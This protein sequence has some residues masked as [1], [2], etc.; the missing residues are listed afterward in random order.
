MEWSS[1]VIVSGKSR[2]QNNIHDIIWFKR[3]RKYINVYFAYICINISG[4]MHKDLLTLA[5]F[6]KGN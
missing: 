6:R 1:R 3:E 4:K 5:V 2:V